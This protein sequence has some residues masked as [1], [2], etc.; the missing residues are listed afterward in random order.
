MFFSTFILNNYFLSK[1]YLYKMKINLTTVSN[2]IEEMELDDFKEKVA[3]IEKRDN[4]TIAYE[5]YNQ[6]IDSI[7]W[8]IKK[9]LNQKGIALSRM[10]ITEEVLEK[11]KSGKRVNKIFNQ[12]KLKSSF[13]VRCSAKE[14]MVIV[15]GVS[16]VHA[17]ETIEIINQFNLYI[18]LGILILTIIMVWIFSNRIIYPLDELKTLAN[19]ISN[20]NFAEVDIKTGDEIEELGNSVN[21]MS[22]KLHYSLN[23]LEKK[24]KNLEEFISNITHELKTPLALIKAYS[25]G[26]QD[27][28]D[29]GTYIEVILK[30]VDDISALVD[31]LLKLSRLEKNTITRE[32]FSLKKLLLIIIEK[33]K[34]SIQ[35]KNISFFIKEEALLNEYIFADKEQ[36]EIVLDNFMN[37]AIKY[38]TNNR[39]EIKIKN[40]GE[41]VLFSIKNG[42]D[43]YDK[44]DI[45]NIWEPFY[46]L[47]RSRDKKVSGTGLGLSIVRAI[48][49]K[50]GLEHGFYLDDNKIEF[51]IF[52][53]KESY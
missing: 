30:H 4:V 48:L 7:N 8:N 45:S 34:I 12:G 52:F 20:L 16:I 37:N 36:I 49:Q 31:E 5:D 32:V 33:H 6:D 19:D 15:I 53:E 11:L 46:V 28:L 21:I 51:Y 44:N 22:K 29:D 3:N 35:N 25:M 26:I 43:E 40:I 13:L 14:N 18:T 41:R 9:K 1:Y 39:I 47:E 38:T 50:H 2:E 42:I 24:N 17:S 27:G 10:W 23:V